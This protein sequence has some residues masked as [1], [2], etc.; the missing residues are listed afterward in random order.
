MIKNY[1]QKKLTISGI[2]F[3]LL[4]SYNYNCMAKIYLFTYAYNQPD[5]IEI[6][7]RTFKKFLLDEYEFI[8]FND[9]S[10]E[11]MANEI[12]AMCQKYGIRCIPIPQEIHEMP[13]LDRPPHGN[14][15]KYNWPN[16]RNCNVVQYSLDILG[17]HHDDIVA[18]FDSDLFLIKEFSIGTFM[19]KNKIAA[20]LRPCYDQWW[21]HDCKEFHPGIEPFNFLWIGFVFL[22]MPLLQD[23]T[24]INFNCGFVH[25]KIKVDSGGYTYYYLNKKNIFPGKVD[26]ISLDQLLCPL[27]KNISDVE[28]S[29]THNTAVLQKIG[30]NNKTIQLAQTMP[31]HSNENGRFIEFLLD[32]TFLH[33][34]AGSNYTGFPIEYHNKKTAL[35]KTFIYDILL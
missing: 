4:I 30:L 31:L 1:L 11:E 35:V 26:R 12:K 27:C 22:N 3:I 24:A 10:Q 21:K 14:L 16:V 20:A 5:F 33:Y 17:I 34:Q 13:Y 18:L 19:R 32:G 29:C 6:Q 23:K 25:G 15:A 2:F 7:Y 9:A 8:V 28:S